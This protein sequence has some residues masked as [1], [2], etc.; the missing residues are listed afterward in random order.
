MI[1]SILINLIF[2][3]NVFKIKIIKN[4][5]CEPD[6]EKNEFHIFLDYK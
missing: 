1:K 6:E 5:A 2:V 4:D 3:F